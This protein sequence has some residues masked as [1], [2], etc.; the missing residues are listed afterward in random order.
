[1]KL[2]SFGK[3]DKSVIMQYVNIKYDNGVPI[4]LHPIPDDILEL[5]NNN[6]DN[7]VYRKEAIEEMFKELK[8]AY[9]NIIQDRSAIALKEQENANVEA[10][11][12]PTEHVLDEVKED[13][14]PNLVKRSRLVYLGPNEGV[15]LEEWEEEVK[16][17]V[18]SEEVVMGIID[19]LVN[20]YENKYGINLGNSSSNKLTSDV[21]A[22]INEYFKRRSIK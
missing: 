13:N 3:K 9:T 10:F 5:A 6:T 4:G 1:M 7:I 20:M 2:F 17:K 15:R 19:G 11:K 14:K 12:E 8:E 22:A 16:H 21:E 18:Y